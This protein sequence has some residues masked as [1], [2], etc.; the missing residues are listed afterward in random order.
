MSMLADGIRSKLL[1]GPII[2]I[3]APSILIDALQT[4]DVTNTDK[5]RDGFQ[6]VF[7]IGRTG[8][9]EMMDYPILNEMLVNTF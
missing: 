7:T 9:K 3:P 1:I 2:P 4:V 6:I 8:V 5:G